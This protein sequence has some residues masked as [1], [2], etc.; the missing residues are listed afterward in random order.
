MDLT[1][2]VAHTLDLLEAALRTLGPYSL[3]NGSVFVLDQAASAPFSQRF[4]LAKPSPTQLAVWVEVTA[5]GMSCYL[6]RSAELPEWSYAWIEQN[7][8]AFQ[9]E[10]CLLFGSHTLVEHQGN[11]TVL[12]LFGP[13]GEQVRQ[14]TYTRGMGVA[15]FHQRHFTLYPPLFAAI[16]DSQAS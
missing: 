12:R 5:D 10:I 11:R 2:P 1:P 16:I 7:P 4:V 13:T 6:D 15:W 9:T 8:A 14:F 3:T